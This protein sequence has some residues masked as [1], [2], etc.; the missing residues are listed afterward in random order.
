MLSDQESHVNPRGP[1]V[2][3][4]PPTKYGSDALAQSRAG[5]VLGMAKPGMRVAQWLPASLSGAFVPGGFR[6]NRVALQNLRLESGGTYSWNVM[7]R[8][9]LFS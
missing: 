4:S 5:A 8:T 2:R 6:V 3:V 1:W 7:P 9:L